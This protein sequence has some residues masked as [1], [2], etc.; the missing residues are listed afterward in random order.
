MEVHLDIFKLIGR[1][2]IFIIAYLTSNE[3]IGLF[4]FLEKEQGKIIK[5]SL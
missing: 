3:N 5:K 4:D 2:A 1:E